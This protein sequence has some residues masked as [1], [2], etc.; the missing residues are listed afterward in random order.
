LPDAIRG[1]SPRALTEA[2]L[3]TDPAARRR[4]RAAFPQLAKSG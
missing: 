4:L 2:M 3:A 1:R